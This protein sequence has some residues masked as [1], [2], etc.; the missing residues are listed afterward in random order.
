M[1]T[2]AKREL[3]SRMLEL[4]LSPEARRE[5]ARRAA[6]NLASLPAFEAAP[7]LALYAA[8]ADELDTEAVF[9]L[10]LAAGKRCV[11]P[12]CTDDRGLEFAEV[13]ALEALVVGR[14]GIRE[15][16]PALPR[17]ALGRDD[18]VLV[19]GL[20]FDRAGRRLGRGA[21]YYDRAFRQPD[22]DPFLAGFTYSVRVIERVPTE[23]HDRTLDVVISEVG[24]ASGFGRSAG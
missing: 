3:R 23:P 14:H 5:A 20:A 4:S 21:G 19:P 22:R 2:E 7:V 10:A 17:V 9:E 24:V 12:R 8:T 16:A 18:L 15:P 11:Y 13:E 6:A 1:S